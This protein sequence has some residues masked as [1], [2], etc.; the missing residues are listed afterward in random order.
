MVDL[1]VSRGAS[2][3]AA[4]SLSLV[5]ALLLALLSSGVSDGP[6]LPSVAA[7]VGVLAEVPADDG[8]DVALPAVGQLLVGDRACTASVVGSRSGR[9]AI[10][11][12]HCVYIPPV[13]DRMPGIDAGRDP[14]WVEGPTFVPAR[15]G[16]EA[17]YGV[18]TVERVWVDR[19]WQRAA[20]PEVDVA[21]LQLSDSPAGTADEVLGALGIQFTDA[22]AAGGSGPTVDVLGYPTAPP[23]D[24]TTVQGCRGASTDARFADVL[25][26]SCELTAGSS[27]GPWIVPDDGWWSVRAVTSYRSLD[28]PGWLGGTRL[29]PVAERLW[30][31]ADRAA[32]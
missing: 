20:A 24:G 22:A 29:G 11:A 13:I 2:R 6:A 10:T 16:D 27:G 7:L 30:R 5:S 15:S 9:I 17:P 21:F 12:A 23:F 1:S 26:T 32:G 18:W 4:V 31:T 28:R 3:C 25:E 14:G 19:A 8:A